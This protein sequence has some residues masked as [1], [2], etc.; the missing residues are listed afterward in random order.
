ME[1]I[2]QGMLKKVTQTEEKLIADRNLLLLQEMK[3]AL[4]ICKITFLFLNFYKE[5]C[6]TQL[7]I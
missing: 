7:C 6:L 1:I 2:L 3:S 4:N 5:N